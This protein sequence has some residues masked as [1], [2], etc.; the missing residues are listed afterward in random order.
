MSR[1]TISKEEKEKSVNF[2]D[3][4]KSLMNKIDEISNK[5]NDN[6]YLELSNDM[7]KLYDLREN[8]NE[9]RIIYRR[10]EEN[11][12]VRTHI[13]RAE[14]RVRKSNQYEEI[15]TEDVMCKKCNSIVKKG[16]LKEHQLSMKCSQFHL[17]KKMCYKEK[18][19]QQLEKERV[20]LRFMRTIEIL[21]NQMDNIF[22]EHLKK[23][24]EEMKRLREINKKNNKNKKKKKKIIVKD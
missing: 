13:R 2:I 18:K 8:F 6:E 7:K 10:F 3:I 12:I 15:K 17:V 21:D 4:I 1:A 20:L 16:G 5:L 22:K 14:M 9:V 11:E 24:N 19:V 23:Y